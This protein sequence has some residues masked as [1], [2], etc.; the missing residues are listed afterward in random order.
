M[1]DRPQIGERLRDAVIA[2][3]HGECQYCGAA[4]ANHV[5]HIDALAL[6]GPHALGN[7]TLSCG[8]CNQRKGHRAIPEDVR[9]SVRA[10]AELMAGRIEAAMAINPPKRRSE[11]LVITLSGDE[12]EAIETWCFDNKVFAKTEGARRLIAMGLASG[13]PGVRL[14]EKGGE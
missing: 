4:G 7:M 1:S 10:K 13:G 2:A 6:G 11:K 5:D 12:L 14:K 8:P 3:Y 9:A